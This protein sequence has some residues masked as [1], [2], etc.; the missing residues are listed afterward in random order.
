MINIGKTWEKL[1]LAAR[2]IVAIENPE[3]I[4]V[5]STLPE[6]QRAALKFAAHTGAK[7]IAGR[8]TPGTFTNYITKTFKEP[9][10]VIVTDP[11]TDNQVRL[12]G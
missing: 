3:D 12:L 8:L 2:A 1:V 5:L 7:A 4:V 6:G 11:R 9:R 10:L